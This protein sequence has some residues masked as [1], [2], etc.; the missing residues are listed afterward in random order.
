MSRFL[1]ICLLMMAVLGFALAGPVQANCAPPAVA[2]AAPCAA[3]AMDDAGPEQRQE[4]ANPMKACMI[5]QC[6]SAPPAVAEV[7]TGVGEPVF[8]AARPAM[9]PVRTMASADPAPEQR[10]P[11]S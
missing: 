9:S 11:I 8:H 2:I 1:R 3:M 6:P 7:G 10:P 4:P 5:V